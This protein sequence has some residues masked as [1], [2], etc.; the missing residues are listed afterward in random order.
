VYKDNFHGRERKIGGRSQKYWF[1][2]EPH[3]VTSQKATFFIGTA[4][5]TSN[6]AEYCYI[7]VKI[8]L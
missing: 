1:L 3:G 6:L 8:H 7:D 2:Q 4:V 5:K